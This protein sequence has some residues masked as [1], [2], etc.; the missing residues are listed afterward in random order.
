MSPHYPLIALPNH[1]ITVEPAPLSHY[2]NQNP[3]W[4]VTDMWPLKKT[5]D[6]IAKPP[7]NPGQAPEKRVPSTRKHIAIRSPILASAA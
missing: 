2:R 7:E 1:G 3:A 5:C 4:Q 6:W